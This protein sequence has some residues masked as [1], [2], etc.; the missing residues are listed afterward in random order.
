MERKAKI[1]LIDDEPEFTLDL[2]SVLE[3]N[4]FQV[5]AATSRELARKVTYSE[6][7]DLVILGTI[8]PRGDA[9]L[10]HQWLKSDRASKD[11]PLIVVDAPPEKRLLKGWLM[12]EG[13]QLQAEVYVSK[14][15][16]CACLVPQIK[17][18]L[19]RAIMK[20]RVLVVDDHPVVRE[21]IC[22]LL[23]L[24]KD[25]EVVGEAVDGQDAINKVQQL[26]PHVALMDIVMPVMSGLEATRRISKE[27]PDTK[28]LIL[29]QYDEEENMFV[30]KQVGA[31][32]F[33]PKRAA[34]SDLMIGIKAVSTGGYF[35]PSFAY[36]LANW[37]EGP[38]EKTQ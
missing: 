5:V 16:E 26:S 2:R 12:Q 31:F 22:A 17:K 8:V 38:Q 23:G 21:G 11:V 35:P 6:R 24:Q 36:V 19:E 33:V 18:L 3:L 25:I 32:G 28:V 34:S 7:P 10:L 9:F 27:C 14:P 4:G 29:T 15:I 1:L 20:I 30:A 13:L 37:P